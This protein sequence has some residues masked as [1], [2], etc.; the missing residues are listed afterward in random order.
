MSRTLIAGLLG[1]MAIILASTAA[2]A[3]SDSTP[4]WDLF[5]GY[6]YLNPGG[7]VPSPFGD[8][9][10]PT[11][12]KVPA[13]VKGFGSSLTYNFD[14]H[15][16]L[17]F[18]LGHNWGDGNYD[19][20]ASVGPRFIWRTDEASFFLHGLAGYN[21]LSVNGLDPRDGIGAILGGGMDL[22]ITKRFAWRVFEADY[23]WAHQNYGD[24]ASAQFPSLRRP[25][26][27]GERLRTGV[28]FNWGGAPA[29]APAATCT[30]QPSEVMVGE[31]VTATVSASNF[32]PKHS[33]TYSWT[34]TGGK[35]TGKDTTATIDTTDVAPGGY[36][37][38]AH[39]T[40]PKA[41][42]NNQASCSANYTIKPLPPKN[43]PTISCSSIPAS[44][45]AG[46]ASTITCNATSPDGVPVTV[47]NWNSSAGTINGTGTTAT[48]NTAGAPAGPITVNA[49]ATD[50]RG[51]TGQGSTQV[52]VENPPPPPPNPQI[53]VL[54]KRLA[55]HSIYFPTAQ[56]PASKPNAGL[57]PSQQKTL[58]A[59]ATDFIEYRE[60][61][62]DAHL[63]LEGHADVR[64]S[65]A[66]NQALSERRVARVKSFLVENGVPEASIETLAYGKQRNLTIDEVR[67]AIEKNPELTPEERQR[68]QKRIMI[69]KWASNRRVDV[70][71]KSAGRTETSVRQFP[72]NA[73]DSLTLI[74]G[75]ESEAKKPA[76]KRPVRKKTPVK[77]P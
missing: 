74:G 23:V 51:L 17:E 11:A 13:M 14:P 73:A 30:V 65:D 43:P 76:A 1:G 8:P 40:D 5:A 16:G 36:A 4:K 12:F 59:L 28:V 67:Q 33:V 20:T 37:V 49:T 25:T 71:L 31:P 66:Y 63:V 21:R 22:N 44:L 15:W 50:S 58:L 19:T 18:D 60:S 6:Q 7:N 32:N 64:G 24:F 69:L 61:K 45:V 55:L 72:F 26:F 27:E 70:T 46:G 39:V 35:V 56:P 77:K 48:L 3:Q 57:V 47:S 75:R 52:S 41:K 29:V 62:P 34:A 54:E 53:E 42:N 38:T 9:N 68:S 2:V 10:N